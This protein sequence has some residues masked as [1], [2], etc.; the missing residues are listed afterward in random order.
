M[1][2]KG[3]DQYEEVFLELIRRAS[4]DLPS[5][6]EKALKKA[7]SREEGVS[8]ETISV[9]LKNVKLAREKSLPICQD[10]G[11]QN[12]KIRCPD[13]LDFEEIR[14][15]IYEATK[16]ATEIGFLRPN[17]VEPVS[18]KNT[19]DNTG[20]FHPIIEM[21]PWGKNYLTVSLLL[22]GGGSENVSSQISLPNEEIGAGRDLDGVRRAV[23]KMIHSAQGRGCSPG[24]AGICIG[25]D[26]QMGYRIAK[27][28]LLKS[29]SSKNQNKVLSLLEKRI[30]EEANQ[31]GI[32]PMGFGGGTTIL[33]VKIGWAER[34][35]ASFFVTM[36]YSCWALRR[37]HLRCGINGKNPV[38]S[39]NPFE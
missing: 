30:E 10:T 16:E 13:S 28:Q 37:W 21:E 31:M 32:G 5:D 35:P 7:F 8:K 4:C 39:E 22:K 36:S 24:I 19:G 27:A 9:I 3:K 38:Y 29:L 18:N 26:R 11:L 2:R 33:G 12:W 17:A 25:G 15:S 20:A 14:H 34:H 23:L 1:K 6:V